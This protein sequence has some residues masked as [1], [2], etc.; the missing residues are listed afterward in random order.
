MKIVESLK[1][2]PGK[3][4]IGYDEAIRPSLDLSPRQQGS[5]AASQ[6][7]KQSASRPPQP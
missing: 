2:Q 5:E 1:R 7:D 6:N 4:A 3:N